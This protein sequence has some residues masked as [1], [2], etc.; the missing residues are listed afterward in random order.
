MPPAAARRLLP[1]VAAVL[2]TALLT[3]C[4]SGNV[5][6]GGRIHVVAAENFWGS[7]AAQLAGS[8]A[9][10]RSIIVNPAEDPHSYEPIA[11]DARTLASAQ[12]AIVNGVGYDPWAP[13][14]LDANP[15]PGRITLDVGDLVG[16]HDGDNPHRWYDPADV[17]RVAAAITADLIKL[18]PRDAGY[19]RSRHAAFESAGLRRYNALI[20][21]IRARFGGTP[22]GCLGEHL[23]GA[24]AGAGAEADHAGA[25]HERDQRGQRGDARRTSSPRS[26]RSPHAR[27]TSGSTT[28]RTQPRRSSD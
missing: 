25:L 13:K 4:G 16:L 24:L 18:A 17:Q 3:S 14:L 27:L 26:V 1:F 11:A 10:A 22:V 6:P 5:D 7:I 20:A 23:R 19:F 21:S 15:V 28:R 9:D 2:A 8:Q 12:L